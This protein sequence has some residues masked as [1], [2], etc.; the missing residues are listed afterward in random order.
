VSTVPKRL[1]QLRSMQDVYLIP[2]DQEGV[3]EK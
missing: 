1:S 3:G 2:S